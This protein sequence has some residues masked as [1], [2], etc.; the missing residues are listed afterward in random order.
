[1]F[2]GIIKFISSNVENIKFSAFVNFIVWIFTNFCQYGILH[3]VQA[4]SFWPAAL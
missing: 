4:R 3:E 2:V 1:M